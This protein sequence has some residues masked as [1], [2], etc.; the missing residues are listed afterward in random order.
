MF[1]KVRIKSRKPLRS[2]A[3]GGAGHQR[4]PGEDEEEPAGDGERSAAVSGQ[5]RE[6]RHE[7]RKEAAS[8]AGSKGYVL[9]FNL[10]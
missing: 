6:P 1:G 2:L 10:Q 8:K 9:F 7:G 5:G 4:S 3:E